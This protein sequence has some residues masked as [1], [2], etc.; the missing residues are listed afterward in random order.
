MAIERCS[1]QSAISPQGLNRPD[2]LLVDLDGV[3]EL[4]AIV[5]EGHSAVLM[6]HDDLVSLH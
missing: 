1:Q 4:Q 2:L 3:F 5:E 6:R